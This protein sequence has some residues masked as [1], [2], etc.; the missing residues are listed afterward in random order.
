MS[1]DDA[2]G[3]RG[4]AL[5]LLYMSRRALLS[6]FGRSNAAALPIR[7]GDCGFGRDGRGVVA[8]LSV[9]LDGDDGVMSLVGVEH[10]GG[11]GDVAVVVMRVFGVVLGSTNG[12]ITA[13]ASETTGADWAEDWEPANG[14]GVV[15]SDV[16]VVTAGPSAEGAIDFVG[17][18]I[19]TELATP[20]GAATPLTPLR[21]VVSFEV[22]N[23]D[24]SG[25]AAS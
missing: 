19:S 10:N 9:V 25:G 1:L 13:G 5:A 22:A 7:V 21:G 12:V 16:V 2:E 18:T 6:T 11:G 23:V 20:A 3:D 15:Y 24:V 17:S 14:V 8:P 4:G